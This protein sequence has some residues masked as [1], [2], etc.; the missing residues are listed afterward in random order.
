[1]L[2]LL[3]FHSHGVLR[4][5]PLR[6]AQFSPRMFLCRKSLQLFKSFLLSCLLNSKSTYLQQN[7]C[8]IRSFYSGGSIQLRILFRHHLHKVAQLLG[9]P[10]FLHEIKITGFRYVLRSKPNLRSKSRKHPR[11]S[12]VGNPI[13]LL[14]D[15]RITPC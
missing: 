15:R 9:L 5:H 11:L 1:M 3:L 2:G 4:K 12:N 10:I 13:P 7:F 14:A 8:M 6:D